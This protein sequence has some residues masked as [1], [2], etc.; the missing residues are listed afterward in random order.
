MSYVF[1]NQGLVWLCSLVGETL[2]LHLKK[3]L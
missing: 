2:T 3:Q 1:A